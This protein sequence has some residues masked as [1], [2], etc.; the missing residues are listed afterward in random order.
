DPITGA[1]TKWQMSRPG[2]HCGNI[3]AA[4]N[5]LFFRS[6]TTAYYDLISDHGTAHFGAQRPGCWI[7]LI[8]ANGLVM[9]PEASSGCVCPFSVHCTIVFAPRKANRVWGTFSAAKPYYPVQRL[10][11]NFG[12]PGDRKDANG[13][14]WLGYPR[15]RRGRLVYPLSL[16]PTMAEGG[17]FVAGNADFAGP[18]GTADRWI[19]PS[20]AVGMKQCD[21]Q[22]IGPGGAPRKYTVRLHF[23]DAADAKPRRR[24]FSVSL[25]GK[26]VL[27]NFDIAQA[28]G[29]AGK[30]VVKQFPGIDVKDVL[31]IDLSAS[32]GMTLLSGVEITAE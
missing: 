20:A 8:P 13:Q 21:I 3:A 7:N 4:P 1:Q 30:V 29:G 16:R 24:V 18:A 17:R 27:K 6:G 12:A 26:T 2:H 5:A 11:V 19:Y 15:P 10:A 28:A 22:L 25:Q 23:A 32:K 14:L 31:T 9:M